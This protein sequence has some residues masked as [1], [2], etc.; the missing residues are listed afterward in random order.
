MIDVMKNPVVE[1][2]GKR[3]WK[4]GEG[5]L[6]RETIADAVHLARKALSVYN[7]EISTGLARA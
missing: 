3:S 7:L 4:N 5:T 2:H 1:W 6:T